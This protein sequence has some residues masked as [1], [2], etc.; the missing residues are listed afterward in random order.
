M[1]CFS[2]LKIRESKTIKNQAKMLQRKEQ[3]TS[4]EIDPSAMKLYDLPGRKFKI[5][6]IKMFTLKHAVLLSISC[7]LVLN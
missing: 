7:V 2:L 4:R 6:V 5:P 1:A 3:D